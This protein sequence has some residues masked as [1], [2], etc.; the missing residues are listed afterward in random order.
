MYKKF[1]ISLRHFETIVACFLDNFLQ[2]V[3]TGTS[4]LVCSCHRKVKPWDWFEDGVFTFIYLLIHLFMKTFCYFWF[5]MRHE[6]PGICQSHPDTKKKAGPHCK[7]MTSLVLN[8]KMRLQENLHSETW[9]DA[10][11]QGDTAEICWL[12]PKVAGT[13]NCQEHW[14]SNFDELQEAECRL[15][16]EWQIPEDSVLRDSTLLWMSPLRTSPDFHGEDLRKIPSWLWHGERKNNHWDIH[17]EI[18]PW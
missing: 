9:K 17:Q 18:S 6:E 2:F 13:M 16:W 1:V 3:G 12:V 5:K 7:A 4:V 10:Q 15:A 8:R 14:N 11:L